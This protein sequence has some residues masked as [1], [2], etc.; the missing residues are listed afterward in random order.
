MMAAAEPVAPPPPTREHEDLY[1]ALRTSRRATATEV[2]EAFLDVAL[3][4]HPDLHPHGDPRAA[5]EFLRL[6][7]AWWVL[8]DGSRRRRY[9]ESGAADLSGF[10]L[11]A[12]LRFCARRVFAD[13]GDIGS[14][15]VEALQV[16]SPEDCR[17]RFVEETAALDRP[18]RR[19]WS[20][21]RTR[22]HICGFEARGRKPMEDHVLTEHRAGADAWFEQAYERTQEAF[23]S[24]FD[25]VVGLG[26]S[27]FTLPDGSTA[28]LRRPERSP[29]ICW[30]SE[31]ELEKA[32]L[33]DACSPEAVAA[34]IERAPPEAHGIIERLCV[35]GGAGIGGF[36]A[37]VRGSEP[38]P[39]APAE[40]RRAATEALSPTSQRRRHERPAQ[41][42]ESNRPRLE[43][44]AGLALEIA[45]SCGFTCGT[46]EALERHLAR[47]PDRTA[48]RGLT[49]PATEA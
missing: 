36:L 7:Q 2:S 14:L 11:V 31:T 23:G 32:L 30:S 28:S 6:S 16:Q 33:H 21:W 45:C 26:P 25:A 4:Y 10:T 41:S 15:I 37:P 1:A 40:L 42:P 18:R 34:A 46:A 47:F 13:A 43:E 9:D 38:D 17:R 48:H 44:S 22:C 5:E 20:P 12:A 27:T 39:A 3:Q 24:F 8:A 19:P 49:A 35:L 29:D